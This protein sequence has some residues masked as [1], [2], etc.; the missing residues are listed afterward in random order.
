MLRVALAVARQPSCKAQIGSAVV[1]CVV[2]SCQRNSFQA[3][4]F[5]TSAT[6]SSVERLKELSKTNLQMLKVGFKQY[7][8]EFKQALPLVQQK[9]TGQNL[10]D[11]DSAFLNRVGLDTLRCSALAIVFLIPGG[12]L[13]TP[14]MMKFVPMLR[15]STFNFE[16]ASEAGAS[17]ET[18]RHRDTKTTET[19]SGPSQPTKPV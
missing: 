6:S 18:E 11:K 15:P 17:N 9:L 14:L 1:P 12:A 10:S 8:V 16:Q 5:S 19:A 3:M 4:S 2:I 7:G 13:L